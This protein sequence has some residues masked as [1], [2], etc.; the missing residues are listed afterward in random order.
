MIDPP[1]PKRASRRPGER[2]GIRPVMITGDHPATALA[3]AR[4]LGIAGPEEGVANRQRAGET[5]GERRG[6]NRRV[7]GKRSPF[8]PG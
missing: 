2:A 5:F 6:A 1:R 3:V 8:T 4:E 7:D